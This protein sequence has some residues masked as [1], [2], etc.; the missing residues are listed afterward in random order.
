[1]DVWQGRVGAHGQISLPIIVGI[2]TN[3]RIEQDSTI[4]NLSEMI[5]LGSTPVVAVYVEGQ[6]VWP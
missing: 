1:M 6:Q 5:Y 3:G 4:L 2:T